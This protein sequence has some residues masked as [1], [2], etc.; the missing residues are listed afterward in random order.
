VDPKEVKKAQKSADHAAHE[1]AEAC[2]RQQKEIAKA[3]QKIQDAYAHGNHEIQEA[4]AK[5]EK[6][7]GEYADALTKSAELNAQRQEQVA[8]ECEPPAKVECAKPE[9]VV[10]PEPTPAPEPRIEVTPVVPTPA[11][12]PPITQEVKP[13]ELPKTA[14]PVVLIGL[15]G[16]ATS[17]S[18]FLTRGRRS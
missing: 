2:R 5:F 18:G 4:N 1:A 3:Q 10:T 15:V 14:S 11:P 13:K 6:R 17:V 8:V 7:R 12:E 9:A 16:L